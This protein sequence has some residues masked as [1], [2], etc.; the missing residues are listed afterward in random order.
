VL[1]VAQVLFFVGALVVGFRAL[2]PRRAQSGIDV[3]ALSVDV[4]RAV[5]RYRAQRGTFVGAD[6]TPVVVAVPPGAGYAVRVVD[7]E[8]A[9]VEVRAERRRCVVR[10]QATDRG[11]G[12]PECER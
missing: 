10:L 4:A 1:L 8:H 6:T 12:R 5:L 11:P 2:A 3:A 9:T 7:A